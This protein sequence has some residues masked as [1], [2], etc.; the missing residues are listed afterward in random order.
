MPNKLIRFPDDPG[1]AK[2]G[3]P[4]GWTVREGTP[5]ARAWL[6]YASEDGALLSGLWRCTPGSFEVSYEK[7]EFCHLISG[8]CVITP[9]DREPVPLRAGDGFVI[10]A[11]FTGTWTVTETM[12]KHFVFSTPLS[13]LGG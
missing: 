11:G 6:Y 9:T 2:I 1:E 5:E 3:P 7:W 12:I 4:A 10:E 13:K 8:A